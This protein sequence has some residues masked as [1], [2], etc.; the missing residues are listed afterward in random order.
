MSRLFLSVQ[1]ALQRPVARESGWGNLVQLGDDLTALGDFCLAFAGYEVEPGGEDENGNFYLGRESVR[2]DIVFQTQPR[3]GDSSPEFFPVR[4][5]LA[6]LYEILAA[7]KHHTRIRFDFPS[8]EEIHY[9]ERSADR[10]G[11][12]QSFHV[13]AEFEANLTA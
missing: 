13:F 8:G 12:L 11:G 5:A 9:V 7:E 2:I 4:D 3:G 1:E 10:I 6:F